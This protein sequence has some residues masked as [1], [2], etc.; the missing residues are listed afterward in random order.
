MVVQQLLNETS[1]IVFIIPPFLIF[2]T[3][4]KKIHRIFAGIRTIIF[5]FALLIILIKNLKNMMFENETK[6]K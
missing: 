6:P 5:E 1:W 4:K 2:M 3:K